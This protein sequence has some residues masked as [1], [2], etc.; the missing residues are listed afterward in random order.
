M[1]RTVTIF[2]LAAS[3]LLMGNIRQGY[4]GNTPDQKKA[5]L[6]SL[7]IPGL[8]QYYAG[9]PGYA[10]MF[11]AAEIAIWGMYYYDTTM[12]SSTRDNYLTFAAMHAGVNPDGRGETYLNAV[13]GFSSSFDYNNWQLTKESPIQYT[14]SNGWNWDSEADRG[15]F[16]QLRVRELDYENAVKYCVA[17]LVLNHL[18]SAL[19]ASKMVHQPGTSSSVSVIP[20]REGLSALYSRSY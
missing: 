18:L 13:G 15:R 1:K 3:F 20:M 8:G 10:K 16:K 17:G 7:A 11:F 9:S 12:K 19:H 14:G 5:F 4:A 6:M 2:I